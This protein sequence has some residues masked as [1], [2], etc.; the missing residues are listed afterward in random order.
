T[1]QLAPNFQRNYVWDAERKSLLIESMM[2]RIPLPMFY[3]SEDKE[4]I[5]EVVDGLQRLTTIRDFILGPDG[6]GKG[7][8]L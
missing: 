7:F 1:I 8:E 5:W 6:D 3:V 4:G 2:L